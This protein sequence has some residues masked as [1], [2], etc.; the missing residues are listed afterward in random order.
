MSELI[1]N[2]TNLNAFGAENVEY[3]NADDMDTIIDNVKSY[4]EA[5][6]TPSQLVRLIHFHEDHPEN[7]NL[8]LK[9]GSAFIYNG[10]EWD[11]KEKVE[12]INILVDK[13]FNMIVSYYNR[14][15]TLYREKNKIIKKLKELYERYPELKDGIYRKLKIIENTP[16]VIEPILS[17]NI[18]D[19]IDLTDTIF[20]LYSGDYLE[21]YFGGYKQE[22][23]LNK[24]EN[25]E[26]ELEKIRKRLNELDKE[27]EKIIYIAA[28]EQIN[29][30]SEE[31]NSDI[32][33]Q[34]SDIEEQIN[35]EPEEQNSDIEEQ[36]SDIEEQ[37]SDIEEQINIEPEDYK[38]VEKKPK[39]KIKQKKSSKSK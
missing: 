16:I 15:K 34:N 19:E 37:N 8:K 1:E 23:E 11:V 28:E 32:E 33:E 12:S 3:I 25:N 39:K 13:A 21:E 7:H 31:Q 4:D 9:D 24:G 30:E 20:G 18:N 17:A 22:L 5:C 2:T 26:I 38:K 14:R 29:I 35:I 36:N 6:T 27:E 10:T